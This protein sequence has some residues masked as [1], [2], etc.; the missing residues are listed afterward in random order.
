MKHDDIIAFVKTQIDLNEYTPELLEEIQ[1]YTWKEWKD[2][3]NENVLNLDEF[4]QQFFNWNNYFEYLY[5]NDASQGGREFYLVR[6]DK[7]DKDKITMDTPH[8]K[9]DKWSGMYWV[10]SI[11]VS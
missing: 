1:C 11:P 4:H 3:I 8:E 7:W 5:E 6:H 9:V 2:Y 10:V